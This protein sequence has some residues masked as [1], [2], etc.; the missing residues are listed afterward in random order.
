MNTK[1][2]KHFLKAALAGTFIFVL[3]LNLKVSGS[4]SSSGR[5]SSIKSVKTYAIGITCCHE[6]GSI[7]Y[8]TTYPQGLRNNKLVER[9]NCIVE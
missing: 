5:I 1:I 8:S 3:L 4:E 6:L 7:C 9:N 2:K